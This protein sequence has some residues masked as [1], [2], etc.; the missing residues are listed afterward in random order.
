MSQ[1]ARGGCASGT[2]L[3]ALDI[4]GTK[5]AAALADSDGKLL[6]EASCP[7]DREATADAVLD[8]LL[9][10]AHEMMRGQAQEPTAAGVSF[11]G[12]VDY[13]NGL[14]V[15]CHHLA[16]WDNYPVKARVEERLGVP[17]LVDNDA[18]VAAFGE[19]V[20]GAGRG[21]R[22]LLY[23]TVSSGIGG[24]VII[25][26]EIYRGSTSLAG[27]IG[28]TI[29]RIGGPKCTCG[30][31]GCLEAI[32]SGWSIAR[33]A[34]RLLRRRPG[35]P[36]IAGKPP[37]DVTAADVA[38]AAGEGH[39]LAVAVMD[40]AAGALAFGIAAAVNIL[41]PSLVV[42]GGGVAKAG[43]VLFVP[44][45]RK[46]SELVFEPSGRTV[47]VVPAELGDKSALFGAVALA[48]EAACGGAIH[49]AQRYGAAGI[50]PRGS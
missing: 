45:R 43:E 38:K 40:E 3:L 25:G 41:N 6:S 35:V 8:A 22:N 18:N 10:L 44:L 9:Q 46:F 19:A 39:A 12:P 11:G 20:F 23:L 16:G 14:A 24:G 32:A 15:T 29:V 28:H 37:G 1:S 48:Q 26:G 47:Q 17:C 21:H 50:P 34:Q 33:R 7:T 30:R 49:R 36:P 2:T 42:L 31:R 4:G 13:D 27:E 5:L